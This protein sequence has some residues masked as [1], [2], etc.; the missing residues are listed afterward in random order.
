MIGFVLFQ[1]QALGG[2]GAGVDRVAGEL[3]QPG[4]AAESAGD[5]VGLALGGTVGAEL[6][7]ADDAVLAIQQHHAAGRCGDPDSGDAGLVRKLARHWRIAW[8]AAAIQHAG[9]CSR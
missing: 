2:E 6:G 7:R 1:P 3:D 5:L 8:S 9:S 4:R